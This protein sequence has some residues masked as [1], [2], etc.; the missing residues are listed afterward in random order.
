MEKK[1]ENYSIKRVSHAITVQWLRVSGYRE[2]SQLP[3]GILYLSYQQ[4]DSLPRI[5]NDG[6]CAKKSCPKDREAGKMDEDGEFVA[7]LSILCPAMHEMSTV[8]NLHFT[9]H[10]QPISLCTFFHSCVWLCRRCNND[11]EHIRFRTS[12]FPTDVDYT[13]WDRSGTRIMR[14]HS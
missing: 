14:G 10:C 2:K 5:L 9:C 11:H 1:N 4:L 12:P 6:G 8:A 13:V 7:W 3:F